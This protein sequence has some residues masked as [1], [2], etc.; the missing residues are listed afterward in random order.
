MQIVLKYLV[1][2]LMLGSV[3]VIKRS[4][5]DTIVQEGFET[6]KRTKDRTMEHYSI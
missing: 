1:T 4:R 6:V 5:D 2:I 3:F